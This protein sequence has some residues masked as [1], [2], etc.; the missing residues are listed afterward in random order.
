MTGR[1]DRAAV[2]AKAI[3]QIIG[4]ALRAWFHGDQPDFAAVL[5][6]IEAVLRDH[7]DEIARQTRDEI[8]PD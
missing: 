1:R 8:R 3:I 4:T 5:S 2:V 6:E 7:F